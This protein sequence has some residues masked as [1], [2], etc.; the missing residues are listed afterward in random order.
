MSPESNK[1]AV[2]AFFSAIDSAQ[3][4][5]PLDSFASPSYTSHFPGASGMDRTATKGF[6]DS[7]FQACPGLRHSVEELIAEGDHVAARLRIRG[8]HTQ[9]LVTPMGLIPPSA[10]MFELEVM[11]LY[12]FENGKVV[13]HRSI[14]D[15]LTFLQQIGAMP[16]Q[17]SA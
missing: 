17:Q 4:M 12:R 2:Q 9:P 5:A 16:N 7:F 13:E 10:K 15:M 14:F 11:N 6:G 3:S 1:A 8:T